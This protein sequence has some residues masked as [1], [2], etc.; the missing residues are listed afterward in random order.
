MPPRLMLSTTRKLLPGSSNSMLLRLVPPPPPM[1]TMT[2]GKGFLPVCLC[3]TYSSYMRMHTMTVYATECA[4]DGVAGEGEGEESRIEKTPSV[5]L[6][7]HLP[8]TLPST[9]GHT[10]TAASNLCAA[11]C[12]FSSSGLTNCFSLH[13]QSHSYRY[14]QIFWGPKAKYTCYSLAIAIVVT[15]ASLKPRKQRLIGGLAHFPVNCDF[16]SPLRE[17]L[18][19]S[20]HLKRSGNYAL[21]L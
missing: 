21:H 9:Q 12:S 5:P 19:V 15:K 3:V 16:H 2:K 20:W 11:L 8:H 14:H 10:Y 6:N 4:R 1:T 18:N 17:H 7:S 13:A